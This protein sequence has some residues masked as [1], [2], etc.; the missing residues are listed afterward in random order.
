M[1]IYV[2]VG[3]AAVAAA[4]T[5][6][7]PA[8]AADLGGSM[9][10]TGYV[11]PMAHVARGP[12][13]PCYMRADV[14]YSF[15]GEPDVKWSTPTTDDVDNIDF[16]NT[17]FGE[18]GFGCGTGSRGFRG[19]LMFGFHGSR[20]YDGEPGPWNPPVVDDPLH[21][22]ITSYTMMFNGYKDLGNYNG[23]TPYVGAGVGFAYNVMN[24]VYFTANPALTNQILGDEDLS[25]AWSVM[26]GFG[27]Q[28][29]DRA[30]IDIGYR[31]IDMGKA[32][33]QSVDTALNFNPPVRFDDL[34]AHEIK[35]GLRYH[36][37]DSGCCNYQPLK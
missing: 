9:K 16:E 28:I 6:A 10:D 36:L 31:Y 15:S 2:K 24:E 21:T 14:G 22:D 5:L 13:G 20:K 26:A 4:A 12:A 35:I 18:G 34:D 1:N 27:Y 3:L 37:G 11:A 8:S 33:S 29:S 32:D 17:W 30:I 19:E 25:F 23:F 7:M